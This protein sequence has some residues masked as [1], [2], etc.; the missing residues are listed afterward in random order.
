MP[1]RA[2]VIKTFKRRATDT[3]SKEKESGD[4][5]TCVKRW[6]V[7]DNPPPLPSSGPLDAC[8]LHVPVL[9]TAL[10]STPTLPPAGLVSRSVPMTFLRLPWQGEP[11]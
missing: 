9:D 10:S 3:I 8:S 4:I 11:S 2:S 1:Y 6:D 5:P 7:T